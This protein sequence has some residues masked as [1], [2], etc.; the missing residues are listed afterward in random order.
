[1]NA[2]EIFECYNESVKASRMVKPRHM[3][4]IGKGKKDYFI[5]FDTETT[6]VDFNAS[7]YL[8]ED[9]AVREVNTPTVFGISLA[10]PYKDIFLLTWARDNC[11]EFDDTI[12]LLQQGY[13]KA[14]HNARYDCRML[15]SMGREIVQPIHCTLTMSRIYWDR[16]RKHSIQ[17]LTEFLCPQLSDW[18]IPTD[19]EIR[20][21]KSQHTRQ[22]YPENYINYSF[23]PDNII[24]PRS[25][26]DSF[27]CAILY[28]MLKPIMDEAFAEVYEREMKVSR[29]VQGIESYGM[30][31]DY[32]KAQTEA[33]KIKRE[34][35]VHKQAIESLVGKINLRSPKQVV[36]ALLKCG[37]AEKSIMKKGKLTSSRAIIERAANLSNVPKVKQFVSHLIEYRACHKIVSTYLLPLSQRAKRNNNIVY[38][39]INPTDT[40][41]GRMTSTNPNLQNI[42]VPVSKDQHERPNPVRACFICR[43]GHAIYYFDYS[44]MEMAYCG[45]LAG[46]L[47]IIETYKGGGDTYGAK[48]EEI[49]GKNYT[50]A[51]RDTTK[52]VALGILY[53]LGVYEM[54]L[55]Y[56]MKASEAKE[57]RD[58]F[59]DASPAIRRFGYDLRD[60]L[61]HNGYVKGAFGRI[62]HIPMGDAYKAI[63]AVI[64]GDCAQI[65]KIALIQIEE[66]LNRKVE[67]IILPLH[68]EFQIET[69][70]YDLKDEKVFCNTVTEQMINIQSLIEKDFY[71]RVDVSR[72]LTNWA[73]KE[74]L[75]V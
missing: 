5:A 15:E 13:P 48:A 70:T 41:T 51:Q 34:A 45:F 63:N 61:Y 53:G 47:K 46:D 9:E 73:E 44:Q 21:L 38:T 12:L 72:T 18:K 58:A 67:H 59:M 32:K 42:P 57:H 75:N 16:R 68:D 22:G 10:V 65:F 62:Y 39:N 24:G 52:S 54:A 31:F 25:M 50:K 7:S 27:M 64:Q 30:A 6:G 4:D 3:F 60:Q 19:K 37:L 28:K 56:S 23:L 74:K 71:L 17:S 29:I 11:Q 40:R 36:P 43:P 55:R 2:K 26:L 14:S 69:K 33:K 66:S 49:Y 8:Y 1:M 35:L 20:R